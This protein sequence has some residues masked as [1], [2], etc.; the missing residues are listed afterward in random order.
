MEDNTVV[1]SF[2]DDMGVGGKIVTVIGRRSKACRPL[3]EMSP[4]ILYSQVGDVL[5]HLGEVP[6]VH[7][8]AVAIS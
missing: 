5:H 6:A 3:R 1:K 4:D 8:Q 2:W 7:P